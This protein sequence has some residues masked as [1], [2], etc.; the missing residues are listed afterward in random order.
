MTDLQKQFDNAATSISPDFLVRGSDLLAKM[1]DFK[2]VARDEELK[3]AATILMRKFNNNVVLHGIN[4]VGL[5]PII[6]GLQSGKKDG[7]VPVDIVSKKFYW[8]DTDAIFSSGSPADIKSNFDKAMETLVREPDTVLV[9]DDVKDFLEGV[10]NHGVTSIMHTLMHALRSHPNL[11]AIIAGGNEDMGELLKSH[12]S[13]REFFSFLEVKEPTREGLKQIIET[14]L[15]SMEEYHGIPFADDVVPTLVDLAFKYPGVMADVAAQPKRS[16][17]IL[18]GALTALRHQE[19]TK[20]ARIIDLEIRLASVREA[21][22]ENAIGS[23]I[24]AEYKDM[25]K[26]ELTTAA[27]DLQQKLE[28]E[29]KAW[30]ELTAKVERVYKEQIEAEKSAAFAKTRVDEIIK[31]EQA[32]KAE[33]KALAAKSGMGDSQ[34]SEEFSRFQQLS[35]SSD[36]SGNRELEENQGLMKLAKKTLEEKIKPQ[37]K[38]LLAEMNKHSTLSAEHI[39]LEYSRVSGLPLSK[40]NEDASTKLLNLSN[41]M[42][43]RVYGQDTVVDIVANYV[44][45][46]VS[47]LKDENKPIGNFLFIGPTGVGKTELSKALAEKLFGSE[48]AITRFDMGGF[49]EKTS[50]NV[51]VGAPPGYEGYAEGGQLTNAVRAKP[52]SVVLLDEVEKAHKDVFDAL[53]PVLDEGVLKDQRGFTATFGGVINIMTSNIGARHFMRT[54]LLTEDQISDIKQRIEKRELYNDV[55]DEDIEES[56]SVLASEIAYREQQ[57][58]AREM[59]NRDKKHVNR[60]IRPLLE[61][62]SSA[63]AKE[64]QDAVDSALRM[65]NYQRA[66]ELALKDVYNPNKENGGSGF[67][68]EFLARLDGIFFFKSLDVPEIILI[69]KKELKKLNKFM[70]KKGITASM[71]DQEV[72]DMCQD[73]NNKQ[74]GG[75]GIRQYVNE[76]IKSDIATTM[77]LNGFKPGKI[78]ITYNKAAKRTKTQF[79]PANKNQPAAPAQPAVKK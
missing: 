21:L 2:L 43:Q 31:A 19:H 56:T 16:L 15:K 3:Q 59:H 36:I 45:F 34:K 47:G 23:K 57:I 73:H 4:G 78:T 14:Q 28:A 7:T 41:E 70:E 9:L 27:T 6:M 66:K 79:E 54:D 39:L 26:Q 12:T 72:S 24:L 38:A 5:K 1:P 55:V 33:S 37:Y 60:A 68:P 46:G 52:N 11:Q 44:K 74:I 58:E 42:K 22:S 18:E 75:R 64:T 13:I 8:L 30:K 32:L 61:K 49:Q 35:D 10:R 69:A 50:V 76:N 20:P 51:L 67:R 62:G 63:S 71:S 40:I 48:S 17:M 77:L 53:L 65:V 25:D 29:Q